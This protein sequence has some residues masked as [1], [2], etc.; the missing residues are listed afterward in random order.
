MRKKVL[1]LFSRMR[2]NATIMRNT[3]PVS[4][5]CCWNFKLCVKAVMD[6]WSP[7][8]IESTNHQWNAGS[9]L[10]NV[11]PKS[12]SPSGLETW[13]C[14]D[15][16][17]S[18]HGNK[19][20]WVGIT[21]FLAPKTRRYVLINWW[22]WETQY[23]YCTWCVLH[24]LYEWGNASFERRVEALNSGCSLNLQT[25]QKWQ[26]MEWEMKE[27]RCHQIFNCFN[28][29]ECCL[30]CKESLIISMCNRCH[31]LKSLMPFGK[32]SRWTKMYLLRTHGA[33]CAH[34]DSCWSTYVRPVSSSD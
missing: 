16:H 12:N 23:R 31:L 9:S 28:S 27:P 29:S 6:E 5:K 1:I 10:C 8:N 24:S 15:V 13:N 21:I 3:P 22:L 20:N 34:C 25:S 4:L 11:P 17:A 7:P 14:Q 26:S 30:H 19:W 18:L 32:W 33:L 2:R